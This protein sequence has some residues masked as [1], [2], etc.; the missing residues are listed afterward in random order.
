MI[1]YQGCFVAKS[2]VV[3]YLLKT[4]ES[5]DRLLAIPPDNFPEF[6]LTLSVIESSCQGF[7]LPSQSPTQSD[8]NSTLVLPNLSRYVASVV[9]HMR[10]PPK[11]VLYLVR[12]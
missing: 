4:V 2:T 8:K 7:E 11:Y 6:Y 12:N 10:T 5:Q 9:I 3:S 1:N